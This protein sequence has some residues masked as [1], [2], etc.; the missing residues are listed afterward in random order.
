[1]NLHNYLETPGLL[2]NIN[3]KIINFQVWNPVGFIHNYFSEL[4]VSVAQHIRE[5]F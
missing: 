2:N 5:W 4:Y 1:M 3:L